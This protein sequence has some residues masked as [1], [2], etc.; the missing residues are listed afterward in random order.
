MEIE[1][2]EMTE[3]WAKF[4]VT[5][6]NPEM[7]NALRRVLMVEIPKLAIDNVEF[8]L[9]PIMDEA[10]HEYES[11]SPLFDEIVAH[12]LGLVPIPTDLSLFVERSKCSCGGEGCPSCTILYLLDKKGPSDVYSGDLEP[13]GDSRFRV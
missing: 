12:R 4:K 13:L 2:V 7:V 9:G 5:N 6:S 10:G 1:I 8:H 3:T 11:V